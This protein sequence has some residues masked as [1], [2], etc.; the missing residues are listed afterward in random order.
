MK[1]LIIMICLAC[2]PIAAL[3]GEVRT[4]SVP[5][6]INYQGR[7]EMDNA[8]VT[9][10]VHLYFRIYNALSGGTLLWTSSELLV[11]ASQGIF[12]A[13]ITPPWTTFANAASCYLEVQVEGDIL[14]P[15]EP[16]NSVAYALV[17]KKLEDGASVSVTTF[18][19]NYQ[20]LLATSPASNVG[21]GTNLPT[22]KLTVNGAVELQGSDAK[23][24]WP[25]GNCLY[26]ATVATQS[27][28]MVAPGNTLIESG[29]G[30]TGYMS[31]NTGNASG[32]TER[33]RIHDYTNN[34]TVAIG[35]AAISSPKAGAIDID[36]VVYVSTWG[37]S[38][39]SGGAVPFNGNILVNGGRFT[40]AN[41][42]YLSVGETNNVIAL[43]TGSGEGLRVHTNGYVGVGT[44]APAYRLDV[45]GDMH[46]N[47][48][49]LASAVS[50]GAYSGWPS[51]ANEVRSVSGSH[52]LLQQNNPYFVGIGTDT[53]KE[54][55]HVR[56]SVR[57]DYGVIAATAAFSGP[58]SVNGNFTANSGSGNSVSLS[59]TVVYGTLLVTGGIGSTAGFPAYI[60]STQTLTGLNTFAN[61]LTVSSDVVTPN[62]IGV[63]MKDFNFSGNRYLQVGDNKPEYSA[64]DTYAYIVGG[65]AANAKLAFYRGGVLAGS[66]ETQGGVNLATVVNG[67]T[68]TL[69][70]PVYHRI[71]NG[72]VWISTGYAGTPSIYVSSQAGNVGIGT[73][74]SDPNYKLTLSGTM[75]ITGS[76]NG[77]VF[78]DGS[79]MTTASLGSASALANSGDAVVAANTGGGGGSVILRSG[80]VDG[81]IVDS[82]GNIG[83]GTYSPV[84]KLNVR[85]GDLVLGT[86]VNPYASNGVEDLIVAGNIVFDGALIQRSA[87]PTQLSG[88]VV[89]GSV[90]LSTGTSQKTGVATIAPYTEFDVNGD[91]QFG[92]GVNKSTFTAAGALQLNSP[93]ALAYGGTAASSAAGAR[94][95]LGVPAN[96]GTGATGTWGVGISGNAATATKFAT[97]RNINS[98]SFDGTASITVPV[99]SVN[100]TAT[101][102]SVYPLWTTAAGDTAASISVGRISF[103][104]ATG[105]LTASGFS[106][107]ISGALTGNADT[108]TKLQTARNINSTSF[109]GTA[110]ITVPVHSVNDTATAS[111]VYPLWTTAAGDT[112]ANISVGR[113]SFVP[114]TGVLTAS[115]FSGPLTGNVTG[116]VSG[117]AATVTGA[118]QAAITSLG[119]LTGLTMGGTLNLNSNNITNGGTI[120]ATTFSGALSGNASTV[121]N[122]VYTT[123]NQ[124]IAGTKTFSSTIAGDINGNAATVTGGVYT[125]GN[126]T[127]GGTKTF[128]ST[129]AGDIS[130]NAATATALAGNGSNCSAGNYPL[131]VDASGNAESCTSLG[132]ASAS[133]AVCWKT[134][135]TLGYCSDQPNSSG[136]CTCN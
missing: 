94:T 37:V 134:A 97:A 9:G 51:A 65:D 83:V 38:E 26:D 122:G 110:S 95:S 39:R 86:P 111:S 61:L 112:A 89:A 123:G 19:A 52:L 35:P 59:S 4:G 69:T 104:P 92:L 113:I 129:I 70:D 18:T 79:V 121:T 56:G 127:I 88:L 101:A 107:P 22:S 135:T 73:V 131:G 55:L 82:G 81:L 87:T 105:I 62:R 7:L 32:A 29:S 8:P 34:G 21:I 76:G 126:Q 11:T 67:Q 119:T 66:M 43:V 5:G 44:P 102:S 117:S 106:G 2:A 41:A 28:G 108:A 98:T 48:G 58:V 84:S 77:V 20:V 93:L 125:S 100:D 120:T 115:G 49:L 25:T 71:Q 74:V 30:G 78:P 14:T 46:T 33:M 109:D 24:C 136:T 40:G 90:Y 10:P 6:S 17:A 12:S 13:N 47:T 75:H 53:P 15:R 31:F 23:V 128:S 36:G 68:R 80:A 54:K 16:L 85:G 130:G 63:A 72:V 3:A 118:A 64:Q 42:E 60:A 116:N 114:A 50:A 1:K 27:G 45:N 96:D 91:A 133:H 57:A 103:V 132:N 124:T 99:H